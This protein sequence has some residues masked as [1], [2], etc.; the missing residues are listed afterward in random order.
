MK[1]KII[2]KF[3]G[4]KA[5]STS[6]D[7]ILNKL[8]DPDFKLIEL[9]N[10]SSFEFKNEDYSS[11]MLNHYEKNGWLNAERNNPIG[12]RR[13]SLT[14]MLFLNLNVLHNGVFAKYNLNTTE[15]YD[16][17]IHEYSYPKS[18][19]GKYVSPF[20]LI[21]VVAMMLY[22]LDSTSLSIL[23]DG[24]NTIIIIQGGSI[25]SIDFGSCIFEYLERYSLSRNGYRESEI[26]KNA[27]DYFVDF[28]YKIDTLR[29]I[30][31][32]NLLCPALYKQ[33]KNKKQIHFNQANRKLVSEMQL[34]TRG[35]H[36][37]GLID[38]TNRRIIVDESGN[39]YSVDINYLGKASFIKKLIGEK[40]IEKMQNAFK[41]DVTE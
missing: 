17:L 26:C 28:I 40:K 8:C 23:P 41:P 20:D 9:I 15:E 19:S 2:V 21:L 18:L 22:K 37:M 7:L 5:A 14:G 10:N 36:L 27:D 29:N 30:I 34:F 6:L 3:S 12:K 31:G 33:L 24:N 32:V 4:N 16:I 13:F 11:R 38:K 25:Q 35:E 39:C 1:P